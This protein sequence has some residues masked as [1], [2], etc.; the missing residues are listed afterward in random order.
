MVKKTNDFEVEEGIFLLYDVFIRSG[1]IY[2]IG[3]L[4]S[5][6]RYPENNEI[7]YQKLKVDHGRIPCRLGNETA[8][9][10]IIPDPHNHT[11]IL[12][13]SHPLIREYEESMRPLEVEIQATETLKKSFV[14]HPAPQE[15][16]EFVLST[17]FYNDNHLIDR[18]IS[19]HLGIGF[20]KFFLYNNNPANRDR[21]EE[22]EAKY[23]QKLTFIDWGIPR[24]FKR[25]GAVS[26]SEPCPV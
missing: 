18:W 4:Y 11:L 8:K 5:K 26:V 21:Y 25:R 24:R 7:L 14:L 23:G 17:L 2:C 6:Q 10:R 16:C 1:E 20:E 22:L 15:A 3:P 12:I 9:S 19:Y 13:F